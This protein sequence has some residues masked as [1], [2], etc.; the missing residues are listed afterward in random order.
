M[1]RFLLKIFILTLLSALILECAVRGVSWLLRADAKRDQA[2]GAETVLCTGDSFV[3]GLGGRSFPSQLQELLDSRQPGRY[4]VINLGEPG[5]NSRQMLEKLPGQI[6]TYKPSTVIILTGANNGWNTLEADYNRLP[7]ALLMHSAIYRAVKFILA[8]GPGTRKPQ[9]ANQCACQQYEEPDG[10]EYSPEASFTAPVSKSAPLKRADTPALNSLYRQAAPLLLAAHD[11]TTAADMAR[12]VLAA[13]PQTPDNAA[14]ASGILLSCGRVKEAKEA[15]FASL[16]LDQNSQDSLNAMAA[17]LSAEYNNAEAAKYYEK[18]LQLRPTP[19]AYAFLAGAKA[20][21]GDYAQAERVLHA[22]LKVFPADALLRERLMSVLIARR[23]YPAA[24][25]IFGQLSKGPEAESAVPEFFG[26]MLGWGE[27]DKG[28]YYADKFFKTAGNR[29]QYLL[30]GQ[31]L[32]NQLQPKLALEMLDKAGPD[33]GPAC[34]LWKAEA[35]QSLCEYD[36]AEQEYAAALQ[37]GAREWDVLWR[38]AGLLQCLGN[39][40]EAE[41]LLDRAFKISKG[42]ARVSLARAR[43]AKTDGDWDN[44]AE[45]YLAAL[46]A[47]PHSRILLREA[48]EAART[49]KHE[50]F[51]AGLHKAIPELEYNQAYAT[52][53]KERGGLRA[54]PE[55]TLQTWMRDPRIQKNLP[56]DLRN[57]IALARRAGAKVIL[58]S[59]PEWELPGATA[60]ARESGTDYI[61]FTELFRRRFRSRTDYISTDNNHCNADG[62]LFMAQEY[63]RVLSGTAAR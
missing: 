32:L 35:H 54:D 51:I 8:K 31:G 58:S 38:R 34:H 6:Q 2:R 13:K 21:S 62:Y 12:A 17:S 19:Q 42:D 48:A 27:Y 41:K 22:G 15:A 52:V 46:K 36:R 28:A 18:A 33:C 47:A 57:A 39:K 5:S 26:A 29:R 55:Q 3:W 49:M 40:A 16:T 10:L 30:F 23:K 61:D 60:A 45:N 43:L 24:W 4:K 14:F 56:R 37:N 53:L 9:P 63:A 20:D 25:K 50:T 7:D 44:T 11:Y 59:Y 1:K